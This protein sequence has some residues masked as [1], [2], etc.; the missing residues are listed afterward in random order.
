[1]RGIVLCGGLGTRLLP[2][3]KVANKHLLPIFSKPMV[4]YPI[5]TLVKAGIKDIMIVT[6]EHGSGGF[7][8]LL[9]NGR[10]FGLDHLNYTLQIGEGGIAAA[11]SLAEVFADGEPIVVIL[12]DN[13]IEKD[14]IEAVQDFEKRSEE[15]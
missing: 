9:G 5:E 13:L 15:H 2:L 14:I 6:G 7:L 8:P 11:L 1:M 3:T 12:G 10:D 4:F